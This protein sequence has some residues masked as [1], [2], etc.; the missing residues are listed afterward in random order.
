MRPVGFQPVLKSKVE[1]V[2]D[3][4]KVTYLG[5]WEEGRERK[6]EKKGIV[7]REP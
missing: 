7:S 1:Q 5:E 3:R 4:G 2:V 6:L